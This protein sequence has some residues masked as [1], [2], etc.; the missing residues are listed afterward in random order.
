[1]EL[2]RIKELIADPKTLKEKITGE[3]PP[4]DPMAILFDIAKHD[5][6]LE[7]KR[8]N[9]L[10]TK[11]FLEDGVKKQR[12]EYEDIARIAMPIQKFIVEMRTNFLCA[13]PIELTAN[14]ADETQENLLQLIKKTW[15][16][17]KLDYDTQELAE[18]MMSDTEVAELWYTEPVEK[19]YWQGTPN[20]GKLRRTRMK[21]LTSDA[22]NALYPSYD[23]YGDMVA[24]GRSY[25]LK[26]ADGKEIEHFDLYTAERNYFFEIDGAEVKQSKASE[27][28]PNKKIPI[29]YYSQPK[30][31]WADVQQ[32]INQKEILNSNHSETNKYFAWPIAVFKG[33]V[34][35]L[36]DKDENGKAIELTGD[37]AFAQYLTWDSAPESVKMENQNIDTA[38]EMYTG[39]PFITM[40]RMGQLGTYSGI[41]LKMLF[42]AAHLK[43]AAKEK[44]FGK[45]V[46]RRLNYLKSVLCEINTSLAPA[47]NMSIKPKFTL[48]LPKNIMED[49]DILVK[50]KG[51]DLISQE[52][53]VNQNPLVAD[54]VEEYD[55]IKA[56]K[57]AAQV[58]AMK[59]E[60]NAAKEDPTQLKKA[61]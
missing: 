32:I 19:D 20:E 57:E 56:E 41:A 8:P 3:K 35:S 30:V 28:N 1:M 43:A 44:I 15:D 10:V 50:A 37:N 53:A 34:E 27:P 5:V 16:D 18:K 7:K 26:N 12:T 54:G 47:Q 59:T 31:E 36:P 2:S 38:I 33:L 49:I 55:K 46:Q 22:G 58:Q 11:T 6:M 29:I 17:N 14:P 24:F 4:V 9:K 40:E 21:I 13:N 51:A 52:T 60:A 48:F 42:M 23:Q 25:K 61:S 45:G 39:T